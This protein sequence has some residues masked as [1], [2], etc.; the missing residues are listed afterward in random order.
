[1]GGS[2]VSLRYWLGRLLRRNFFRE[3]DAIVRESLESYLIDNGFAKG[4]RLV[5]DYQTW[6][7]LAAFLQHRVEIE[8]ANPP[9][10][11]PRQAAIIEEVLRDPD[12]SDA[13]LANIASTTEKQV[14]RVSDA[15]VLRKVWKQLSGETRV[16]PVLKPESRNDAKPWL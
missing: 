4:S 9:S 5:A 1:M 15:R 2:S 16:A 7:A 3:S 8:N 14:S 13:Q 10:L 11:N 6:H 12:I